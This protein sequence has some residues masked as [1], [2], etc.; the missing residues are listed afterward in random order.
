M[1]NEVFG[2]SHSVR[3]VTRDNARHQGH[4]GSLRI[5]SSPQ[6]ES[7]EEATDDN[8]STHRNLT[9]SS[10]GRMFVSKQGLHGSSGLLV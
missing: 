1:N 8:A 9:E 5:L 4:S 10:S 3:V 7:T 6:T 2:T